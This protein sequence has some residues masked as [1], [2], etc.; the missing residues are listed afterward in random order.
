MV[1]ATVLQ[2][3]RLGVVATKD[4]EPFGVY[5]ENPALKVK[6]RDLPSRQTRSAPS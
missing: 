1:R 3:R 5:A 2:N 4:L 6:M